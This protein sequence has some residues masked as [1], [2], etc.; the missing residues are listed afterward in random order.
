MRLRD[1]EPF[2]N[3]RS[4][5]LGVRLFLPMFGGD[6]L[7]GFQLDDRELIGLRGYQNNSLS[8]R[9]ASGQFVGATAFQKYTMELRY[10][11]TLNPSA[12]IYVTSFLEA[13]NSF[14]R[15]TIISPFS[16]R[17]I[18]SNSYR[19]IIRSPCFCR[20]DCRII[21]SFEKHWP[22]TASISRFSHEV[23]PICPYL[24]S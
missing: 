4:A 11:L 6:G 1:F 3:V 19:V 15:Q 13:G 8:P 24:C 16:I 5:G 2:T 7:M 14:M 22:A 17:S 12:T 10:P 9:N 21:F 18:F 20:M 23:V